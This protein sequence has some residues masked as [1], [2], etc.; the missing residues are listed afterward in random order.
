MHELM[1]DNEPHNDTADA[2]RTGL[3]G[4]RDAWRQLLTE[5]CG[6]G[7]T[8]PDELLTGYVTALVEFLAEPDLAIPARLAADWRE[9]IPLSVEG[10]ATTAVAMGLLGEALRDGLG[11]KTDSEGAPLHAAVS[12]AIPSFSAAFVRSLMTNSEFQPSESYWYE[13]SRRLTKERERRITQLAILNDVSTALASTLSLD[14]LAKIIHEQCGR[15]FDTTNFY[16]ATLNGDPDKMHVLYHHFGG[17]RVTG[18]GFDTLKIGLTRLVIDRGEPVVFDDYVAACRER[19]IEM[20]AHIDQ[21][22]TWAWIGVPIIA[23]DKTIGLLG[24]LSDKRAFSP[25]D[26]ALLAAVARQAGAA[27]KNARLYQAQIIQANQLITINRIARAFATIRDP[28]QLAEEAA[29]RIQSAFG[30]GVVMIFQAN[31]GDDRLVLK[32]LAGVEDA[33]DLVGFTVRAGHSGVVGRAAAT[34]VPVVVPDVHENPDYISSPS[35]QHIR[36]E[37]AVPLLR[38]DRL[39]GVLNVESPELDAFSEQDVSV[40]TTIADQLAIALENAELL[41]EEQKRRAEVSLILNAS[42]VAN[43]SLVLDDVLQRVASGIAD[44]TGLPSCVVYLFDEDHERLLPSAFV[45]REGSRLDTTR[46]SQIVPSA[47]SSQLLKQIAMSAREP[48]ALEMMSCEVE[49][50]LARVLCA[51]AVLAVPFLVRDECLGFALVV[52][53]DD[54]YHFSN[55]QL[56]VAFGIADSAAL[57]LENAR[58]YARSHSLGMAEERIRVARDI[59]DGIAQ[60]L[61]AISLHLEASEQMLEIKPDKAKAKLH[62]ALELTRANLEDARRSVLDLRASA[63]QEL[64]LADALQHRLSQFEKEETGGLVSTSF[65][66]ENPGGRISSRLEL[67][68]YRIFEEALDNVARHAGATH[69]DVSLRRV[70]GT[71]VLEINDNGSGFDVNGVMRNRKPGGKFGLIAI[72]ER[73]RLLH[74]TLS[75]ES[76]A[77][78]TTLCVEVPFEAQ[79]GEEPAATPAA[80]AG[81]A[82]GG[83]SGR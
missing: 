62:R 45:A 74:G 77:A 37:I 81:L 8:L 54:A 20:A 50:E 49:D 24:M 14:E 80:P 38:E 15:L 46:I 28:R 2:L 31:Q 27:I 48:C 68:L 36:S 34:R 60:G 69:I 10:V 78:G 71:I 11:A 67:S 59:H 43:S 42:Q 32:T 9:K 35:T 33:D 22:T 40:L 82:Y 25:E 12:A 72:R 73:V 26:A 70:D 30:Y 47:E 56:R 41:R 58:L 6:F 21:E 63:L 7:A 29:R 61:T 55:H 23:D 39:L 65:T 52:S 76:S 83:R 75:V 51:S 4:V 3:F 79:W 13:I 66:V 64:T 16:I 17:R 1:L 19:G 53:H 57:A 44:A 18:E 5:R